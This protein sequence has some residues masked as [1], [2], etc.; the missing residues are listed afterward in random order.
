MRH[1]SIV[2]V[3]LCL[4]AVTALASDRTI[5]Y[6]EYMHWTGGAPVANYLTDLAVHGDFIYTGSTEGGISISRLSGGVPGP[7]GDLIANRVVRALAV[8]GGQLVA[9]V[10]DFDEADT[11][12]LVYSLADPGAPSLRLKHRLPDWYVLDLASDGRLAHVLFRDEGVRIFDL[13]ATARQRERGFRPF[14]ADHNGFLHLAGGLL[15]AGSWG[16]NHLI[17]VSDPDLPVTVAIVPGSFWSADH[18]GDQLYLTG[19]GDDLAIWDIAVPSAPVALAALEHRGGH[20]IRV[21]DAVAYIA[22]DY[23]GGGIWTA[24]VSDPAV[25]QLLGETRV[26]QGGEHVELV[27]DHA[28]L[29]GVPGAGHARLDV[30]DVSSAA[31][32][33]IAGHWS[34]APNAHRLAAHGTIAYVAS[35][36]EDEIQVLSAADPLAPSLLATIPTFNDPRCLTAGGGWLAVSG[37]MNELHLYSTQVPTH[38]TL[39]TS[40]PLPAYAISHAVSDGLIAAAPNEHGLVLIDISS[41]GTPFVAAEYPELGDCRSLVFAD[42]MLYML[43]ENDIVRVDC[44]DPGDIDTQV[45]GTSPSTWGYLALHDDRVLCSTFS[46]DVYDGTI[47]VYDALATSPQPPLAQHA[48]PG[49]GPLVVDGDVLCMVAWNTM[50]VFDLGAGFEPVGNG[51]IMWSAYDLMVQDDVMWVAAAYDHLV[52]LP[53]HQTA[54]ALARSLADVPRPTA[55]ALRAHPNPFNPQTTLSFVMATA[56]PVRLDV[57]DLAGRHVARLHDGALGAGR[58]DWTWDGRDDRGRQLPTGLYLARLRAG[59]RNHTAKLMLVE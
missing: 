38:P 27:G 6:A 43:R 45:I 59:A 7:V 29:A 44:T 17:D 50:W 9:V 15:V 54:R 47:G 34:G 42:R 18:E 25:P 13:R 28:V 49:S 37:W 4:L 2:A 48:V 21:R 5:D 20:D 32:A 10:Q 58:H 55:G 51:P 35:L 57:F 33:P 8:A 14:D 40:V 16:Q 30:F 31:S 41:P 3:A 53:R 46:L 26:R 23:N 11:T 1:P 19:Y 39:I 12:L 56:R 24:D 22:F 52:M 36:G